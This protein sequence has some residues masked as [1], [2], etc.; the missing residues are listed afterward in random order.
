MAQEGLIENFLT[1]AFDRIRRKM[2]HEWWWDGLATIL[3]GLAVLVL[4]IAEKSHSSIQVLSQAFTEASLPILFLVLVRVYWRYDRHRPL[5]QLSL[6]LAQPQVTPT[7]AHFIWKQQEVAVEDL[8]LLTSETGAALTGPDKFRLATFLCLEA[9]SHH[10]DTRYVATMIGIED[11]LRDF[12]MP[13]QVGPDSKSLREVFDHILEIGHQK[14]HR[15]LQAISQEEF[16]QA[17][18]DAGRKAELKGWLDWHFNNGRVL[19]LQVHKCAKDDL[20]RSFQTWLR[21][22]PGADAGLV[23]FGLIECSLE[24]YVFGSTADT[25][26][27]VRVISGYETERFRRL[28]DRQL[29]DE[30]TVKA[31]PLPDRPSLLRP[32]YDTALLPALKAT[33]QGV[34][35]IASPETLPVL[36]S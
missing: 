21:A 20:E 16:L 18:E 8:R 3:A 34:V 15:R 35:R 30:R 36:L 19:A 17:I 33:G 12:D 10:R 29:F 1:R 25:P 6:A 26:P 11:G 13:V 24:R 22:L 9:A 27:R 32:W 14:E 23:D 28:F 5:K 4:R 31:V 7:I 2:S